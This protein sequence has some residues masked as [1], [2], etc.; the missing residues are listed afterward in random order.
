MKTLRRI[1]PLGGA[2]ADGINRTPPPVLVR[3][4]ARAQARVLIEQPREL[5]VRDHS[6]SRRV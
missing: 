3:V 4:A 2:C 6:C 5:H 1:V